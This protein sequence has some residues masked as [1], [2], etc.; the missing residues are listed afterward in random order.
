[1]LQGYENVRAYCYNC[2]FTP[3]LLTRCL[4]GLYLTR[5]INHG[6]GLG[7]HYNGHCIT[8]WYVLCFSFK[9]LHSMREWA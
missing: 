2:M 9:Y 5:L 1:M 8:R 6:V 7:Q 4:V 3:V